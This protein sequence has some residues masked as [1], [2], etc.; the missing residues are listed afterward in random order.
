MSKLILMHFIHVPYFMHEVSKFSSSSNLLLAESST[1]W[2]LDIMNSSWT[3]KFEILEEFGLKSASWT[4]NLDSD[5]LNRTICRGKPDCPHVADCPPVVDWTV[6][7]IGFFTQKLSACSCQTFRSGRFLPSNPSDGHITPSHLFIRSHPPKITSP[8]SSSP[9]TTKSPFPKVNF[10][11]DSWTLRFNPRT[12][13]DP[14]V[15]SSQY[16]L[17]MSSWYWIKSPLFLP[18]FSLFT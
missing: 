9:H 8:L 17:V 18:D 2:L 10:W 6:R 5:Y 12:L 1:N 7:E 13:R 4:R 14:L 15:M 11:L 16:P 3:L